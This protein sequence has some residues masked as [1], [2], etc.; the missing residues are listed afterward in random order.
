MVDICAKNVFNVPVILEKINRT[1]EFQ[2]LFFLFTAKLLFL[3]N[4]SLIINC[5]EKLLQ[6]SVFGG[7]AIHCAKCRNFTWFPGVEILWKGTVSS[8]PKLCGN[9]AFPQNFYTRKLGEITA[10]YAVL[11]STWSYFF[12]PIAKMVLDK[13]IGFTWFFSTA[14]NLCGVFADYVPKTFHKFPSH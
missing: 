10:F 14:G 2:H 4:F 6:C 1:W 12:N 7:C 8:Y 5:V 13:E 3:C 11:I 9:C